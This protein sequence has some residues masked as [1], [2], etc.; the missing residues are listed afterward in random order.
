MRDRA[1]IIERT[2]QR[3]KSLSSS[4]LAENCETKVSSG[5]HNEPPAEGVGV[6]NLLQPSS[7][8]NVHIP[9]QERLLLCSTITVGHVANAIMATATNPESGEIPCQ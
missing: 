1:P 7:V 9:Q 2:R 4:N 3:V 8:T 5:H 6:A